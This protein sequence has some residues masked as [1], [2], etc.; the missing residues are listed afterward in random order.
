MVTVEEYVLYVNKT[1]IINME[2]DVST[3]LSCI[4]SYKYKSILVT[5]FHI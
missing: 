5:R 4:C 2:D 3:V 1:T